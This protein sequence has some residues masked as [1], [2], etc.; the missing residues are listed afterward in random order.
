M[1]EEYEIFETLPDQSIIWRTY[2]QGA[3]LALA[4]LEAISQ[5]TPNECFAIHLVSQTV[6]ARVNKAPLAE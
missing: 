2:A 6:I 1:E 4:K 5:T 3:K